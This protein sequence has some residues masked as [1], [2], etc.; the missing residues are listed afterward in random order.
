M[1]D[2]RLFVIFLHVVPERKL[3]PA[4]IHAHVQHLRALDNAGKLVLCGPLTDAPMGLVVIRAAHKNEAETVAAADPFVTRGLRTF[5][6][7]T[8]ELAHAGNNY[9]DVPQQQ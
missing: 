2:D 4:D 3:R 9:Q 8:W 7:N 6:V 5:T 1:L